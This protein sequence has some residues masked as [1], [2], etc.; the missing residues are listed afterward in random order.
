[1]A[2]KKESL[3]VTN[4]EL[5]AQA[6]GWD[7]TTLAAFSHKRVDWICHRGHKWQSSV[8]ERSG[9]S[10]CPYCSGHRVLSGFN[11]L[12]TTNPELAAQAEGWDPATITF[13]S[14]KKRDWKCSKGHI[15][16]ASVNKRSSKNSG[17][18][19]CSGQRVL[20]GFNDLGTTHPEI[21]LEA[22]GWDPAAV[23]AGSSRE[24][25]NWKCRQGH[26][27]TSN[28]V[29]RVNSASGCAVCSG[30]QINVGSNDL[31]TTHPALASEAHGWDPT[32]IT[33]GSSKKR[34][35]K[36]SNGHQWTATVN[37]RASGRGC[38]VCTN[39]LIVPGF[40]DLVT[41]HPEIA[42]EADGWDPTTV[43][44][45]TGKKFDWKCSKGHQW[46]VSPNQRSNN[47]TG[48]PFCAGNE[49]VLGETD[50]QTKFPDIAKQAHDWDPTTCT[51]MSN[52]KREWICELGHI[53]SAPPA[54]RVIGRGCT[55]CSNQRV[56]PGFNDLATVN[57]ELAAEA[58]GWDPT[59]L[60]YGSNKRVEWICQ[61]GHIWKTSVA[62]RYL[63]ETGCPYCLNQRVLPGFND[64]ATVNP[65]LA[66]EAHGWDPTTLASK[67]NRKVGWI[68]SS[69]H[70]WKSTVA[71]RTQGKGC[72]SCAIYGF[73]PNKDG[74]LYFIENDALDM[75]QIGITNIPEDRLGRHAQRG[76]EVIEVRGPMDGS[77]TTDLETEIL[78][79]L[80]RRGAL[81]G[82][83]SGIAKF[84]G[85]SESWTTSSLVPVSIS[86]MIS[87]V[88]E[89]DH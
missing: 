75:L 79:A 51:A 15:W 43:S 42:V 86:Q 26:S 85:Y 77:I 23:T 36:C 71:N 44:F 49:V 30:R 81:F 16:L 74:W 19:Y 22:D 18:P 24:K 48:C 17:C 2:S 12:A 70:V 54:A 3:S 25:F 69:G 6:D 60:A 41:T 84:D 89:D 57:P 58:H 1:M 78:R 20:I 63:G 50:L 7:P 87:W 52:I 46:T 33:F 61:L 67:S 62:K 64:L 8:A 28:V 11:D 31:A 59:I 39:R 65:E 4:A 80:Q 35:W 45:G 9:G 68:C 34:D 56:L 47:N 37:S 73:D 82:H 10:G 5:A 83:K 76:W 55:Y 38:P 53:W 13:G 88:Y 72:P 14:S 21:A 29:G 32:T 66:A 40:N 27:W